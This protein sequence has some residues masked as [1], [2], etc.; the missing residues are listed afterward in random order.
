MKKRRWK[1]SIPNILFSFFFAL[2]F[3]LDMK[4]EYNES[5]IGPFTKVDVST[6]QVKDI[7][8]YLLIFLMTYVLLLLIEKGYDKLS[9]KEKDKKKIPIFKISFVLLLVAWLPYILTYF[10]GGI[11]YD[12]F[13]SIKQVENGFSTLTNHNPILYTLLLKLFTTLG[14]IT[15][16]GLKGGIG[17]FLIFQYLFCAFVLAYA[18]KMIYQKNI[19]KCFSYL[20]LFFFVFFPLVPFYVISV[21]KDTPFSFVLFLFI[22]FLFDKWGSTFLHKKTD[23]VVYFILAF[24]VCFLRNNGIIIIILTTLVLYLCTRNKKFGISGGI[25][26]LTVLFIQGPIY[27]HFHLNGSTFVEASAIPFSQIAYTIKN[28]ENVSLEEVAFIDSVIPLEILKNVYTPT[29]FDTIKFN[30]NFND[31][32]FSANKK[33]FLKV[34]F[35][36]FPK[37]IGNYTKAYLLQT[38]GFWDYFRA[39]D[40]AYIQNNVWE[41][42][43]GIIGTDI[44]Q[45][46]TGFSLKNRLKPKILFSAASFVWFS[47]LSFVITLNKRKYKLIL[48]YLPALF[49]WGSIMIGTPIA[50]SLRYVYVFVLFVPLSLI[51]PILPYENKHKNKKFDK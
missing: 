45:K 25:F 40:T 18:T 14:E 13:A 44:I 39:S 32:I 34:W 15:N 22:L 29:N 28:N 38:L 9:T 24:F 35:K 26:L 6:F 27:S 10:P 43:Y 48:V 21:W 41:N 3:L 36:L 42:E 2:V 47:L 37:N 49:L 33:E 17:Y 19:S 5:T 50:F 31:Y 46:I 12:T 8:F 30:E 51:I 7:F 20:T 16:V 11:Y 1:I 23:Y 4:L